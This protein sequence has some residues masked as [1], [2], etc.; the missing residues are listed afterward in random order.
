[1][2]VPKGGAVTVDFTIGENQLGLVDENGDRQLIAGV[3]QIIISNGNNN[4]A[5]FDVVVKESKVLDVVPR[6]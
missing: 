6:F 5:S 4:Q 2:S 3:H 1:M